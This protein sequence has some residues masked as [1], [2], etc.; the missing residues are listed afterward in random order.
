MF[1]GCYFIAFNSSILKVAFLLYLLA[2]HAVS[3]LYFGT[4]IN[5]DF[6]IGQK[7]SKKNATAP[8][9]STFFRFEGQL[10]DTT[11]SRSF[12]LTIIK[13]CLTILLRFRNI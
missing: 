5:R 7:T 4:V 12:L 9:F 10:Y 1:I 11:S 6:S 3:Y 2:F 8:D 13:I